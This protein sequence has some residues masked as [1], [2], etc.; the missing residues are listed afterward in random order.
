[1]KSLLIIMVCS[2]VGSTYSCNGPEPEI[3]LIPNDFRGRVV[4][5]F[6]QKNGI[7]REYEGRNRVYKIPASG[8][9]KT[10]FLSN[11]GEFGLDDTNF[12]FESDSSRV[13]IPMFSLS[14]DSISNKPQ[15]FRYANGVVADGRIK[16][17]EFIVAPYYL[18][19]SFFV[20]N[21]NGILI[22]DDSF[23]KS[24]LDENK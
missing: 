1:M 18:R 24:V 2:I 10:K 22:E 19:D 9:L 20:R 23:W 17:A 15:I 5:L 13:S 21:A 6:N 14:K 4:I 11:T 12:F 3:Y 7:S 8:V 16:Y